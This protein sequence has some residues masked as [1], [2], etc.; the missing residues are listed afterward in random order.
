M[1]ITFNARDK[2]RNDKT[3]PILIIKIG[4]GLVK[5]WVS[6]NAAV[7]TTSESTVQTMYKNPFI[8]HSL[9][10]YVIFSMIL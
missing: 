3:Y 1:G 5:L 9:V 8:C 7:P 10:E 6:F 4:R 2:K